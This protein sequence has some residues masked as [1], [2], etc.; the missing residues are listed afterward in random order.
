VE[1]FTV[2]P[3]AKDVLAALRGIRAA[4]APKRLSRT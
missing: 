4:A 1:L 2:V 3:G